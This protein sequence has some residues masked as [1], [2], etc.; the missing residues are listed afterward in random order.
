MTRDNKLWIVLMVGAILSTFSAHFDLLKLCCSF[1]DKTKALI[2]IA[3]L[4]L[5][6]VSGLMYKSPL[7]LSDEGREWYLDQQ[8]RRRGR[9]R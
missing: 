2:E 9:R 8:L 5:A 6:S 3:S 7:D 4:A 1:T